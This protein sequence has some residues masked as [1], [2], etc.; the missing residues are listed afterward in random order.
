MP[1]F[2]LGGNGDKT[3]RQATKGLAEARKRQKEE[4]RTEEKR[5]ATIEHAKKKKDLYVA[6]AEE[7]EAYNRKRR[8]EKGLRPVRRLPPLPKVSKRTKR[9]IARGVTRKRGEGSKV[10]WL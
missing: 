4:R 8:A 7:R 3:R 2:G 9:A 5:R 10:G 1:L 6:Q